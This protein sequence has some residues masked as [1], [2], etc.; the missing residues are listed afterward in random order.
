M[1]RSK[2]S[3]LFSAMKPSVKYRHLGYDYVRLLL[4]TLPNEEINTLLWKYD[5]E[6]VKKVKNENDGK[7]HSI[8]ISQYKLRNLRIEVWPRYLKVYGSWPRYL[9]GSNVI[10]LR[11]GDVQAVLALLEQET[12]LDWSRAIVT[13]L[14]LS[15][16]LSVKSTPRIYSECFQGHGIYHKHT[17]WNSTYIQSRKEKYPTRPKR[18]LVIY[19]KS[20]E[21]SLSGNILRIEWRLRT[22]IAKEIGI[23]GPLL[24]E[25]LSEEYVWNSCI[26]TWQN[27]TKKFLCKLTNTPNS[28]I[29]EG[30][31][32]LYEAALSESMS[33]EVC[34]TILEERIST[35]I[36]V[37]ALV[38]TNKI[39]VRK[40]MNAKRARKFAP[41]IV[42]LQRIIRKAVDHFYCQH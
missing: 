31:K 8:R 28:M 12:N 25:H 11:F 23:A 22:K 10:P 24:A 26:K 40:L 2:Q 3:F 14:E 32:G 17:V 29:I 21:S 34:R 42:E 9:T 41:E 39:N 33:T 27:Q 30:K 5:G 7:R 20:L 15:S 13:A 36:Q 19:D 18:V 37:G 35:S 1:S 16:S 38:G 6:R 4:P